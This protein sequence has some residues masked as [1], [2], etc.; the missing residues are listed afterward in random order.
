MPEDMDAH[1]GAR[2][3]VARNAKGL[4]LE[5]LAGLLGRTGD[6]LGRV[7]TGRIPLDR[8]SL[9][10]DIA[11]NCDVDV[12][13]LLGQPYRLQ[14]NGGNI[15]HSYIPAM[16]TSMRRSGLILS[17][18]PGLN[19]QGIPVPLAEM[20]TRS[21]QANAARQNADLPKAAMLLP[22]L[23]EDLNTALL[24]CEGSDR[25]EALRLLVDAA[26]TARMVLNQLGYPDFAWSSAEVA[27]NAATQIDDPL[28]K[29]QVAWDRCGALLHQASL[30]ETVAVAEAALRDL[31]P[32][33]SA[34]QPANEVLSLRGALHLRCA[35]AHARGSRA[36]DAWARVDTALEDAD[37]LG[38]EWYDLDA[39][40]VFGRGT[41]AVHAAEVGVEINQP[42]AGLSKVRNVS[43][44][45]VPSKERKIHY[46]ID[47]ARAL[48][49]MNRLPSAVM[50]LKQA[51]VEAPY[52]VNSDPMAR[53]LVQD[54]AGVGVPSQASVLSSLVRSM[55]LVH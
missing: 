39:H 29:A 31:E 43:V 36:D 9:I 33:A 11:E 20:R 44:E 6:W 46:Q 50:T 8:Y 41:V 30:P 13:W 17:G 15:A 35:I 10:T 47:K 23:I 14:Q 3:R 12:V 55:E 52:Y 27:A 37:R 26:R 16:R 49:R 42:D 19:P 1:I 24:V 7:E 28:V 18:H 51:S 34:R 54:L 4:T 22:G 48:R 2:V 25:E 38:A 21:R 45:D 5:E 32:L 40:T 53:A